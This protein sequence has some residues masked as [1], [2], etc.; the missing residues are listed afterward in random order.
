MKRKTSKQQTFFNRN[1]F[2]SMAHL[3]KRNFFWFKNISAIKQKYQFWN[4]SQS[5]G[6][7]DRCKYSFM[8]FYFIKSR[9]KRL[10]WVKIHPNAI[11]V[12]LWRRI[13][14]ALVKLTRRSVNVE[15]AV[16]LL[17]QLHPLTI[18]AKNSQRLE[19]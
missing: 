7:S 16:C 13:I 5:N 17:C 15:W 4:I 11:D 18:P 10:K 14:W 2:F 9:K 3:Y 6:G 12:C 8:L 1:F 19:L